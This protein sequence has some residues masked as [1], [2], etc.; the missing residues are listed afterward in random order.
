[1]GRLSNHQC[2]CPPSHSGRRE[3]WPPVAATTGTFLFTQSKSPSTRRKPCD[4]SNKG[5]YAG[6]RTGTGSRPPLQQKKQRRNKVEKSLELGP[7][8]PLVPRLRCLLKRPLRSIFKMAGLRRPALHFSTRVHSTEAKGPYG[9]CENRRKTV[10]D[11]C[12]GGVIGS[13]RGNPS[14]FGRAFWPASTG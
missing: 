6:G 9:S 8:S 12:S 10:G 7:A 13:T 2:C 1:M 11:L 5:R 3:F 4:Q 14:A